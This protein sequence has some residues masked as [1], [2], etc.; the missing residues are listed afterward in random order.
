M[1]VA[2]GISTTD[3][4][5]GFCDNII[6]TCSSDTSTLTK[7]LSGYADTSYSYTNLIL[8]KGTI[9]N[10]RF[11]YGVKGI[12]SLNFNATGYSTYFHDANGNY[13]EIVLT[14]KVKN[15]PYLTCKPGSVMSFVII[16]DDN[17]AALTTF[18]EANRME[19]STVRLNG[20]G[21][22]IPKNSYISGKVLYGSTATNPTTT[23]A[24]ADTYS[25]GLMKEGPWYPIGIAGWNSNSRRYALTRLYID[26]RVVYNTR[27][28]Q[29]EVTTG[30]KCDLHYMIYN[31]WSAASGAYVDVDILWIY[32]K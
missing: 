13:S 10:V 27:V 18:T 7:A 15:G 22:S 8:Q 3:F 24:V 29:D 6:M 21:V 30:W 12:D 25:P 5:S 16:D 19:I 11:N 26:N 9:I 1:T 20:G 14:S 23:G 28:G 31:T 17:C 32:C 4:N 2:N